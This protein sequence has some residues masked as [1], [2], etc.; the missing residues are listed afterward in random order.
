MKEF[1]QAGMKNSH[2]TAGCL[3]YLS[4]VAEKTKKPIHAQAGI[5]SAE[6]ETSKWI[7]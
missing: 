3:G 1:R 4:K 2:D 7:V 6:E 5:T